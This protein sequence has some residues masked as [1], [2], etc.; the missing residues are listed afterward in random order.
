MSNNRADVLLSRR[1]PPS[2]LLNISMVAQREEIPFQ[3]DSVA[4][5]SSL[6]Y[7]IS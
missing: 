6:S 2:V 4:N 5:V 1:I 3:I 7:G